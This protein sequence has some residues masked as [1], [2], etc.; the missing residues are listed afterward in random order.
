MYSLE[1]YRIDLLKRLPGAGP[2]EVRMIVEELRVIS[3]IIELEAEG[4]KVAEDYV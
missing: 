4:I 3:V 1:E 2:R